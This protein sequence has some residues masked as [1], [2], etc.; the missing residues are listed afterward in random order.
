MGEFCLFL[1]LLAG[2]VIRS[3]LKSFI[4]T[5]LFVGSLLLF[6]EGEKILDFSSLAIAVAVS[7][8]TNSGAAAKFV[9]TNL[10]FVGWR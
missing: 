1:M 5:N 8:M 3:K 4:F 10:L 6:V 9:A 2:K 7:W